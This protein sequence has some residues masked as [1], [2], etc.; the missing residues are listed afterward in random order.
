MQDPISDML[1]IIRNGQVAKKK[2]VFL[3]YSKFKLLIVKVLKS[4]GFIKDYNILNFNKSMIELFLKYFKNKPVIEK[5]QRISR[6]GLRIYKKKKFIPKVM[7]GMGIVIISTS[8][9]VITDRIARK[10]GIGGEII[11]YVL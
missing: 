7:G 6:P 8:L 10:K 5:I 9:G 4:E 3:P 11:C 2:I 1:T